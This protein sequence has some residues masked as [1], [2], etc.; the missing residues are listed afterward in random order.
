M[1]KPKASSLSTREKLNMKKPPRSSYTQLTEEQKIEKLR[2]ERIEK[3]KKQL[4]PQPWGPVKP[5]TGVAVP[6][7]P[8]KKGGAK[9]CTTCGSKMKYAKG[10]NTSNAAVEIYGVPNAGRTD[11][12]GFKKGGSTT[13]KASLPICKNG[14]VRSADGKCVMERPKFKNGGTTKAAKFA[15]L[16]APKNK[17]TFADKIA[18]AKKKTR[19]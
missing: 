18:G 8:F 5:T 1:L 9:K 13:S 17:I 15:A 12:L 11:Q 3:T 19:K 4:A 2:Q 7:E 6:K 10:G 14:M 16:A